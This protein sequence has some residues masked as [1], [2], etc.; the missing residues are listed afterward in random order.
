MTASYSPGEAKKARK[1]RLIQRQV[2]IFGSLIAIL[3]V[4]GVLAT[5]FA[6]GLISLPFGNT[7]S[8]V[9]AAQAKLP[10]C[11]PAEIPEFEKVK[12][13]VFNATTRSGF[14][15]TTADKLKS[16]G[17]QIESVGNNPVNLDGTTILK[18]GPSGVGAAYSVLRLLPES[19]ILLT[20]SKSEIVEV[21]LG[22]SFGGAL[23][24]NDI[25]PDTLPEVTKVSEHCQVIS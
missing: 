7:F 8:G 3:S 25:T 19:Q 13:K 12:V 1:R 11:T 17:V 2:L 16:M 5:P 4:I 15:K 23:G 24:K 10:P 14:A 6:L 22:E 20:N 21:L 18:T 9:S